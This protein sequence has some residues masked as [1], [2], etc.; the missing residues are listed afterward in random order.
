MRVNLQ[1]RVFLVEENS[2]ASQTVLWSSLG[3]T[4][5]RDTEETDCLRMN[6]RLTVHTHNGLVFVFPLYVSKG[7]QGFSFSETLVQMDD[8]KGF[9]LL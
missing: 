9:C 5:E 2:F 7:Q 6:T 3:N 1:E 4:L 8:F